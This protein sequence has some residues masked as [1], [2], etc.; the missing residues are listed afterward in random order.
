MEPSEF[1]PVMAIIKRM[2]KERGLSYKDLAQKIDMSESGV[3]K[4]FS[5]NDC[6]FQ[7][8]LQITKVLDV[9][10]IDILDEV[11]HADP[12]KVSFTEKQQ[13][14]FLKDMFLFNFY[15]K[16]VIERCALEH[17]R[18]EYKLDK[19][20]TFK[21][22]RRLDNLRLIRLLP[23]D[24]VKIPSLQLVQD[25]GSGPFMDKLYQ[26]W[27]NQM[28]KDLALPKNQGDGKFIVR[29][30]RMR[31]S[32][33]QEFISQLKNIEIEY[34]RRGLREMSVFGHNLKPMKWVSMTDQKSFVEQL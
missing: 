21:I 12:R 18:K 8:M 24:E 17:I 2:L 14:A 22:L 6:S 1:K 7:K 27:G 23:G 33:Y 29:C 34:M 10:L 32:T 26:L 31:D 5:S 19:K 25:F 20:E 13:E 15:Y 4:L 30:I 3:K 28:V 11:H 16:L 9:R